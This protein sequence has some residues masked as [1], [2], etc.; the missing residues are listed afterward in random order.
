M[1]NKVGYTILA[2]GITSLVIYILI[3]VLIKIN[4]N[5]K[6]V[7]T[8]IKEEKKPI[9]TQEIPVG[10]KDVPIEKDP[11][12]PEKFCPGCGAP[13]SEEDE[14]CGSCGAPL[15]TKKEG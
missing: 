4:K 5:N 10:E 15:E 14:I 9:F 7:S 8:E 13:I 1:L 12:N 2:G 3:K 11:I 6:E